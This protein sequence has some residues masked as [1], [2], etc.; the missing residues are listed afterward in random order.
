M[1]LC[2][3]SFLGA[4]LIIACG[5]GG[6]G[7]GTVPTGGTGG[8]K[9]M[10]T[11]V[12]GTVSVENGN[13]GHEQNADVFVMGQEADG[14]QTD[15]SGYYELPV[16][17]KLS[18]SIASKPE[19]IASA[20]PVLKD[21]YYLVV[22]SADKA[23]GTVQDFTLLAN[24][25]KTI[26]PVINGVGT[27]SGT[28][29]LEGTS[30]YS[31]VHVFVPGTSFGAFTAFDGSFSF[32]VPSGWYPFIKVDATGYRSSL[33]S[34]TLVLKQQT[35]DLGT[36]EL[37][38]ST[39]VE[40]EVEINADDEYA[41]DR[42]VLL[43][44][45]ATSD[46]LLMQ[47]SESPAFTGASWEL[48]N[49]P[50]AHTFS[51]GEGV[52]NI[53]VNF[54]DANG[55]E[56]SETDFIILDTDPMVTLVS[57][58]SITNDT[59]PVLDWTDSPLPSATYNLE[60]TTDA[61]TTYSS[62]LDTQN[63][64]PASTTT[65]GGTP[66]TNLEN[67]RWR[68]A[69]VDENSFIWNAAEG[70]F[71]V[72][73]DTVTLNDPLNLSA[74]NDR[75][76]TFTW[77]TNPNASTYTLTLSTS[78]DL[79]GSP[80]VETGI[81]GNTYTLTAGQELPLTD[82][83]TY[84]WAVTPVDGSSIE[85]TKSGISQFTLDTTVPTG[86]I[87]LESGNAMTLSSTVS[88]ALTADD[89]GLVSGYYIS[90]SPATP[91][92]DDPGWTAVGPLSSVSTTPSFD[93]S[94]TSGLK[95]V[96][97]WYK[98]NAG[99]ISIQY[100]DDIGL[101]NFSMITAIS[102][103]N[104]S[105]YISIDTDSSN[106][107]HIAYTISTNHLAYAFGNYASGFTGRD[108]DWP[109]GSDN[110]LKID[111]NNKVHIA[112]YD[113]LPVPPYQLRYVTGTTATGFT[114]TSVDDDSN[115]GGMYTGRFAQMALDFNN[116]AHVVY[117]FTNATSVGN[118]LRYATNA[119]GS[120]KVYTVDQNTASSSPYGMW[121]ASIAVNMSDNK[122]HISYGFYNG[123]SSKFDLKYATGTAGSFSTETV[124]TYDS[125]EYS[126]IAVETSGTVHIARIIVTAGEGMRYITGTSGSWTKTTVDVGQT[127]RVP[128][129]EL[130]SNNKV[131]VV[132]TNDAGNS[133]RY[134]TNVFGQW[135]SAS[136]GIGGYHGP[137]I[138]VDGN[139]QK[140]VSC[141][142]SKGG[143]IDYAVTQ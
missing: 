86:T 33:F 100:S 5:G 49:T 125:G 8:S 117:S 21:T 87:E 98:D 43:F 143:R 136:L 83:T 36:H 46:A 142:Y 67:Y 121:D 13:D 139:D 1:F 107:A 106:N 66:L 31:S 119:S 75:T 52:R 19:R 39:G 135:S 27:V 82:S 120:W 47:I 115:G 20:A 85:G 137:S 78:S 4:I 138:A 6:G 80:L 51:P 84:Y 14:V 17:V 92:V 61:D 48:Y 124:D 37:V 11:G 79:S 131:H 64:L 69:I 65:Y 12:L 73:L 2:V 114:N 101:V 40:G 35:T 56:T 28:I 74:T 94:A 140:H 70:T 97:V 77:E 95:T 129:I 103:V 141:L 76:P 41:T 60:V 130:D 38:A 111:K 24:E 110:S 112:H 22:H 59:T 116:K 90:E 123:T 62:P 42:N 102:G 10:L 118:D 89:T 44:L 72:D 55:L 96:Y 134:A 50:V 25:V 108:I 88:A 93:L 16:D 15:T 127:V 132:Y 128:A 3:L 9:T 91:A 23:Y 104:I 81:I 57:P 58:T 99:N 122:V 34:G 32:D 7:G 133:C 109:S 54:A 29:T 126:A 113:S 53:Y 18:G 63:D 68:V 26:N 30:D 45:N 105:G 71:Q